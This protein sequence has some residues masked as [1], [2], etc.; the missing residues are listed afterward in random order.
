[1][2]LDTF[3]SRVS[4]NLDDILTF[5]ALNTRFLGSLD[6]LLSKISNIEHYRVTLDAFISRVSNNLD[7]ILTF[8]ALNTRFLGSLD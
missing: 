4:N 1:M 5:P 2:T 8:P 3:I 7:D 6:Q